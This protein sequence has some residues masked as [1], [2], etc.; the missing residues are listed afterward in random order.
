MQVTWPFIVGA[1]VTYLLLGVM[2]P[3][4][5]PAS[6]KETSKY[7][8]MVSNCSNSYDYNDFDHIGIRK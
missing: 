6:S 5:L 4:A 3:G 2:L 8:K 7:M 1:A